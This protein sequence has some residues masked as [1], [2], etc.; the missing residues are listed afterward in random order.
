MVTIGLVGLGFIGKSHL[1]AY[2]QMDHCQVTAICTRSEVKDPEIRSS[3]NGA[4]INDY[5]ALLEDQAIDVIDICLP[6][7]LHE[8]YIIKAANAGK[9]IICEKPLTLSTESYDRILHAVKRNG[10]KLFVGHILRFWP[11][12]GRIKSYSLSDQLKDIEVVHAQ[13]L[14][15]FPS[16]SDWFK[17]PDKSGGALFDLHIHDIDYVYYLLGEVDSVYA[18]GNQ[19]EYG[20]WNQIMTTLVF[21][22]QS[23]AYVEAS[24]Q[25]PDGYPF[26]M[27]FRAQTNKEIMEFQVTAGENI[28][29]IDQSTDQL[30]YYT[31]NEQ[32]SLEMDTNDPFNNELS[33]FIRCIE[34]DIENEV[35]PLKDVRYVI[36]LLQAI[37]LSLESGQIVKI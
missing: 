24:N 25:M 22:N 15:Q 31:Q 19:N 7:Y 11:A 35:I 16:W 12:Y 8:E 29:G 2:Q 9:H 3:Y 18:V 30:I 10:V 5:D 1:D 17:D 13:R 6:T 27:N 23:K 33:Y 26:T 14:S 32:T 4:F 28:E 36:H 37:Q 34:H 21:K 20:A